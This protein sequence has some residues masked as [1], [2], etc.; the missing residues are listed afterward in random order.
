MKKEEQLDLYYQMVLIRRIEE[1][2]V[3]LYRCIN[4]SQ[5]DADARCGHSNC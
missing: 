1:K 5:Y 2:A 3:E 4:D